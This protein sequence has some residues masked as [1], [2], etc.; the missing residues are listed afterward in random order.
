MRA[1]I[2][3]R[4]FF[5]ICWKENLVEP[6]SLSEC[7]DMTEIILVCIHIALSS[8]DIMQSWWQYWKWMTIDLVTKKAEGSDDVVGE[9]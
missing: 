6:V 3:A 2:E 9:K 5:H 4:Y 1:L 7:E 8:N